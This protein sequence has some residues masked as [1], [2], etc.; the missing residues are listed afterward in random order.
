M[1]AIL[2][3][4]E[5]NTDFHPMVDFIATS[6]LRYAL[7]VKP[8]I[9]ISHIRQFWSTARIETTDEGTHILATVDGIQRT[10]SEAS[11]R[12]NLKHRDEDGIVSIPDTELFENLTLKGPK[13][14]GFNEFSSNIATALVCVA[15]NRTYNF[16]KMIF[17]GKVK[18]VNNKVLKFLIYPRIVP[19]FDTMLVH[20]G[21]GSGTPTEPHHTPFP[22]VESS[23]PTTSLIPL[24]SIP[25]APIPTVTQPNPTP[26][27]QYS[28]SARIAQ[29]S[30]LPTVA[31][32]LA[33]PVR[34]VSEGEACP[35]DSGFIADQDRATIA[36]SSTLPHDL[37]PRVTSSTTD[38][39]NMQ[40]NISELTALYATKQSGEDA[41]IKGISNNEREAADKRISNDLEE[42]ARV[43]TSTDAA[44]ILTGEIDVPTGSGFIPTAGPLLLDAEVARIQ[45]EEEIQGM[46]DSLEKSNKTIAKYLQE[47]QEFASELPLEKKIELIS[48][49]VKYHEHYTKVEDFIHM[50]S[51]EETERLKRKGLNLEKEQV[52]KQKSSEEAP[53][54]ETTTKEFTKEKIK[55]MMQEDLNQLW[56]LVKEYLSIRPASK[57][58]LYDLSGVH[59]VTAKDKE[60]FMLVEKDYPLTRVKVV[61]TAK[62]LEMPLPGVCTAIEEM[63]K[64]LP[65]KD[66]WQLHEDSALCIAHDS[67]SNCNV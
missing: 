34:D 37:A 52:K 40:Q 14:T 46:I 67:S 9:F 20:Q 54:I 63:M 38:E 21:K 24:P 5:F 51:K 32:E 35:T 47:Y 59:H 10:M 15:T 22:E 30:T 31:D 64:K 25:T 2:E 41:L 45:T 57:W 27:R 16:S 66:R 28:R 12:R 60:I 39:G 29:S 6:P 17:D 33:S 13:S 49:L 8:T 18:N 11:L 26:I 43:L 61:P 23:H 36:K 55:E 50:G 65:V 56:A 62:R 7:T 19:L 53:E 44:T 4:G 48:D 58:K 1:V 42:I 3:K